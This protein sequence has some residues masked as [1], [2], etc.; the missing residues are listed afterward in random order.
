MNQLA[1]YCI[2]GILRLKSKKEGDLHSPYGKQVALIFFIYLSDKKIL[3][4]Q[5]II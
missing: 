2:Y 4:S 1:F 5:F 3:L